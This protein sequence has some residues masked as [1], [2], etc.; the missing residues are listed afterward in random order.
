M[1]GLSPPVNKIIEEFSTIDVLKEYQLVGGTAIALQIQHR[2][3]DDLDF[4]KWVPN[5][6]QAQYAVDPQPR[7]LELTEKFGKVK[8]NHLDFSQVNFLIEDPIV[9]VTYYHTDLP[10]P[11]E[12]PV[13][14]IGNISA[15]NLKVLS[16]SKLF[17][18]NKR[19]QIRDYYDIFVLLKNEH[20]T[21]EEMMGRATSM[22]RGITAKKIHSLLLKTDF[23]DKTVERELNHLEPKY[24]VTSGELND[25]FKDLTLSIQQKFLTAKT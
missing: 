23:T 9:K 14:I 7:H 2:L 17:L 25:F 10:K 6:N 24:S 18:I 22:D 8:M 3:S 12:D 16:G 5:V 4:C 11:T 13:V 21:L 20:I 19:K 1:E 15:S